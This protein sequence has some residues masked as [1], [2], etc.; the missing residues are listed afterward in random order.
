VMTSMLKIELGKEYR[1]RNRRRVKI[2]DLNGGGPHPIL[3]AVESNSAGEWALM[4]WSPEGQDETG[5]TSPFDLIEVIRHT[6][7]LWLNMYKD[8]NT[9]GFHF[10]RESADA[11]RSSRIACIPITV[12]FEEG[13][14]L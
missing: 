2:F 7:V 13:D 14:G 9:I 12:E 11:G 5:K 10:S 6:R 1:T 3:G 4:R 8:V